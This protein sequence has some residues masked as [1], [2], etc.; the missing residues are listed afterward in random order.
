[1]FKKSIIAA[2]ILL[3]SPAFVLAQDI[4]WSFSPTEATDSL[5]VDFVQSGVGSVYIFS[6]GLFGFDALDLNFT[7]S[8]TSVIRIVGGEVFNPTFDVIGGTRFD[9]SQLM[10]DQA[11]NSGKLFSVNFVENGVN[12]ALSPLY[13]P[14]FEAAVG[15][16]G[17]VLL[18]RLDFEIVG[19]NSTANF[20]F[21]LGL[22]GALQFPENELTP[23]FGSAVLQLEFPFGGPL[24]GDVNRDDDVNFFDITPFISALVH[25]YQAE[26]D[27]DGDGA[28]GFLDIAPFILLLSNP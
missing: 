5:T 11:N 15:P 26:A 14:N 19:R 3:A 10:I 13:D 2:V 12:P 20:D 17:G 8:D 7:I 24:L 21:S 16:N 25:E 6:D 28:V 18:A 4:F 23:V 9:F 1:M 22:Q 27:I